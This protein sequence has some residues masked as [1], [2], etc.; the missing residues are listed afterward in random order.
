MATVN[1]FLVFAG[2]AGSGLLRSIVNSSPAAVFE[3]EWMMFDLRNH[4]DAGRRQ[5]EQVDHFFADPRYAGLSSLGF[6]NKLSDIV[7]PDG[8]AVALANHGTRVLSLKRR[9]LVKQVVSTL[10]ALRTR[11]VTGKS[12][13]YEP[14][15]IVDQAFEIDLAQFDA[16]LR[17]LLERTAA[18]DRFTAQG[19]WPALELFYEDLVEHREVTVR[20]VADFLGLARETVQL[21][22]RGGPLKQT[23]TDLREVL[24]NFDALRDRYR[25]TP[26]LSMIENRSV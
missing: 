18:Q 15:D 3:A 25:A 26:F 8:F 7:E 9:N 17:R 23:P 10:N 5:I 4:E 13:A 16:H 11:E 20:R 12:H 24:T 21:E 22:A 6:A 14:E 19:D 2:R 1:F